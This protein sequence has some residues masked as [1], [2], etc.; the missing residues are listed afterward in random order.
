MLHLQEDEPP[1][2]IAVPIIVYLRVN[3]LY[4][5]EKDDIKGTKLY[6]SIHFLDKLNRK[7]NHF[8]V[9]W[10]LLTAPQELYFHTYIFHI[11]HIFIFVL[12]NIRL[13]HSS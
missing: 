11:Q 1:K 8:W 5:L 6:G 7:D 3:W 2:F 4:D 9:S 10:W 12:F 13:V